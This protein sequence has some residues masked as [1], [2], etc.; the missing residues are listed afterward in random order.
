MTAKPTVSVLI[1]SYNSERWI[2]Q[3]LDSV[4][5]QSYRALEIIVADDGSNDRSVEII[6]R[7]A[8]RGVRLL[9]VPHAGAAAA[10][11]AAY[12]ACTGDLIQFLD[13]D[14]LLSANKIET[15]VQR[16]MCEPE[17]VAICQWGR[18][19]HD[20][21]QVRLDPSGAWQDS[22]PADW[23]VETWQRGGGM[24]FPAM[25]LVP[26]AI[27]E[28]AGLWREDLSLNDDGEFFTRVVLASHRVLFCGDATAYYRS[29]IVGSLSSARSDKA[30]RSG[31][32][33]IESSLQNALKAE[34]SE[35]MRR[36]G[37]IM[38]QTYAHA[39]YPYQAA[40]AN[41]A[42]RNARKLHP[43]SLQPDGGRTF[44]WASALLGWKTAR[45]LQ[46]W[47]GRP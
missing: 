15:Q 34:D 32:A 43:V 31:Y 29:G 33:A 35:R 25:W 4:L 26:R 40:L 38:W 37:A 30:W 45:T 24:L 3:T 44:R 42:L 23:L 21:S 47:S 14:D 16:L 22:A 18:F 8:A 9:T 6:E 7:Y 28:R 27:I 11:N 19:E 1:P 10:R 20:P 17:S 41:D 5:A 2:A 12:R 36:C 13:A 46:K 39:A